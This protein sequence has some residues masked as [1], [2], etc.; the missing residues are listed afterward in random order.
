M[1]VV[2]NLLPAHLEKE[3]M[4]EAR[5]T[6][7]A[8][9]ELAGLLLCLADAL[10]S[11]AP[12]TPFSVAVRSFLSRHQLDPDYLSV[13]LEHLKELCFR[14]K[15]QAT[16]PRLIGSVPETMGDFVRL[17]E[18]L[19]DWRDDAL[20]QPIENGVAV[21]S[22]VSLRQD[23][24]RPRPSILGKYAHLGLSSEEFAREKQ[25]EIDREDRKSWE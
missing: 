10:R 17:G 14:S 25:L 5:L 15:L 24:A 18:I 16:S 19:R 2:I 22:D 13:A 7:V 3:L 9:A 20:H 6:G 11:G 1:S 12:E 23:P 4:S 8:P 21:M